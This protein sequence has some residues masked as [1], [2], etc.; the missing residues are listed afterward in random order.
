MN[1]PEV[2]V[3]RGES[4]G[5]ERWITPADAARIL[6][7]GT[8]TVEHWMELKVLRHKETAGE[9]RLIEMRELLGFAERH[10]IPAAMHSV[11]HRPSILVVDDEED[12][13]QLMTCMIEDHRPEID[14]FTTTSGFYAGVLIIRHRPRLIFLD[15]RMPELDGVEVCRIIKEDPT[16]SGIHVAAVTGDSDPAHLEEM[17]VAGVSE[18]L[19]KPLDKKAILDL[20]DRVIPKAAG[21]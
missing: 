4:D 9:G 6:D 21:A 3:S 13:L 18:I 16:M 11:A 17:R 2:P 1:P 12:I 15:I 20:V 14:L 5:G 10:G 19:L 7:V 8:S